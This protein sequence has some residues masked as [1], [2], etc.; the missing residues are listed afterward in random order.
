MSYEEAP[1]WTRKD[2]IK[3]LEDEVKRLQKVIFELR[4]E[5]EVL[6]KTALKTYPHRVGPVVGWGK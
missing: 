5:L 4:A 1:L 3:M 2:D 6:K